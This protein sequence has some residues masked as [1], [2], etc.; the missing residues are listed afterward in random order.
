MQCMIQQS[1]A[2]VGAQWF[3]RPAPALV[4]VVRPFVRALA[5]LHPIRIEGIH[6]LPKG[7]ALLVGN[8]GTLGYESPF[9][10]ER[11]LA[12]CGRLPVGLADRWFF[13]VPVL[14]DA[15]VRLGGTYG[16][17]GNA[18][19]ALRCGHLVVCYPGGA[20][21]VLKHARDKY[22]LLWEKSLGFVRLALSAGVPIIPF[23]AAGVDDAFTVVA[24]LRGS[25]E[26]LMGH[27]KYDLPLV[28]GKRGPLPNPVPFWFRFGEPVFLPQGA[29]PTDRDIVAS[30]QERVWSR[31]Q[32]ML[33]DLVVE[34]TG[35]APAPKAAA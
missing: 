10:F 13:K 16:C 29:S 12:L 4:R 30:L 18:L 21:E 14:R 17:A 8:H 15:L 28:W 24:R 3:A 6:H 5:L 7:P 20:R 19:N 23:A 11:I 27:R 25:G 9:F 34:W 1:A 31:T 33:D 2:D 22:R 26:L 32:T 35:G